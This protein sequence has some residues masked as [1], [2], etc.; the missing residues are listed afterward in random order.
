M[1]SRRRA[2]RVHGRMKPVLAYREDGLDGSRAVPLPT[3]R[4]AQAMS[5]IEKRP[6]I[7]HPTVLLRSLVVLIFWA[8][9]WTL[10]FVSAGVYRL[11][12]WV[13][14]LVHPGGME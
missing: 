3:I 2:K 13:H 7:W 14:D 5:A 9:S 10:V 11:H 6:A 12:L 1:A 8:L 4:S